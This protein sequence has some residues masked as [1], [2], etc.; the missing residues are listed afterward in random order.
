MVRWWV[1]GLEL[2]I[3]G[4]MLGPWG[5]VHLGVEQRRGVMAQRPGRWGE[6][7]GLPGW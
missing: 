4:L 5:E 1:L 2:G 3:R 6:I 7:L